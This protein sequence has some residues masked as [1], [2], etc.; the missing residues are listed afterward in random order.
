[1]KMNLKEKERI[2][3]NKKKENDDQMNVDSYENEGKKGKKKGR[4][5]KH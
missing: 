4:K 1:M 3:E 2:K 5:N